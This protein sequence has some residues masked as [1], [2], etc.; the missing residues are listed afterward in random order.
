VCSWNER[1][2]SRPVSGSWSACFEVAAEG[3]HQHVDGHRHGD[4]DLRD[5]EEVDG[6]DR[7]VTRLGDPY[8]GR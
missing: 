6:R 7:E 8:G 1:R 3:A 5:E 4:V 2:L